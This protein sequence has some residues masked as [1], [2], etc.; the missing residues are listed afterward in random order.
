MKVIRMR[1]AGIICSA[2]FIA[3]CAA[4]R[5]AADSYQSALALV[6]RAQDL[7]GFADY[8]NLFVRSQTAQHLD[9]NSGCY[10]KNA[11]QRI[12]LILI[13]DRTGQIT[14]AYSD[15]KTPKAKCFKAAYKGAHMPIPPF[16]PLPVPLAMR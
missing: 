13:V 4:S 16:A 11:G 5:P 1:S 8:V 7:P 6:D 9:Y 15:G 10:E 3:A 14:D 12:L 2:L